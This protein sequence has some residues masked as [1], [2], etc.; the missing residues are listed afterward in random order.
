LKIFENI[1]KFGGILEFIVRGSL[2]IEKIGAQTQDTRLKTPDAKLSW[3]WRR[4]A[5]EGGVL[6]FELVAGAAGGH[7]PKAEF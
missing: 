3:C 2:F 7:P 1:R 4:P 5:A 6:S